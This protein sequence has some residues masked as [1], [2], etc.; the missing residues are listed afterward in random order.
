[1]V[2]SRLGGAP[3]VVGQGAL[4]ADWLDN[5][6][7]VYSDGAALFRVAA[8]GGE[9][10]KLCDVQGVEG[11]VYI[12]PRLLPGGRHALL[13]ELEGIG[14]DGP[15]RVVAVSLE[16]GAID[17][18]VTPNGAEGF[19]AESGHVIYLRDATAEAV[20]FDPAGPALLGPPVP[21][22]PDALVVEG[23][24]AQLDVSRTGT[25]VYLAGA[26]PASAGRTL[27][28]V[29]RDGSATEV[30]SVPGL[31]VQRPRISPDGGR[32]VLEVSEEGRRQVRVYDLERGT[33]IPMP[34]AGDDVDPIW[35][36]D[37][38]DITFA[39]N[40]QGV[41][42][43]FIRAADGTGEE[44]A[45]PEADFNQT[46]YS[47]SPNGELAIYTRPA[48]GGSRDI[49]VLSRDDQ[50]SA[51]VIRNTEFNERSPA[52]SPDGRWLAYASDEGGQDNVY[53][54]RWPGLDQRITVS[55]NGGSAPAWSAEGDELYYISL[56]GDMMAVTVQ[57]GD[58]LSVSRPEA[59]FS[60]EGYVTERLVSGSRPY[61]VAADGRFLVLRD[62][63]RMRGTTTSIT[64][65]LNWFEELNARVPAGR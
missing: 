62:P 54:M 24:G 12:I 20:P 8:A 14:V 64:V 4:G 51:R 13:T 11:L 53:V 33:F 65:V 46:P 58:R 37:G 15:T 10:Q 9:A 42:R 60:M 25:L 48:D 49:S 55:P 30:F 17:V 41:E 44:T 2:V 52:F 43:L 59:L 32:V 1:M 35:T 40:R 34:N 7:L 18:V 3:R 47:W 26:L 39:S 23:F 27:T 36:P 29:G 63:Q 61:D 5:D 45:L 19:Y 38:E 31:A 57:A 16:T 50:W 21:I 22:L 6:T 28:W 56:D